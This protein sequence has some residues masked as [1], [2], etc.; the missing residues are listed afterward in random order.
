MKK[1]TF[2]LALSIVLMQCKTEKKESEKV[3]PKVKTT[4]TSKSGIVI[5]NDFESFEKEVLNVAKTQPT[6]INFWATWCAPCMEEMPILLEMQRSEEY[7][8]MNFV[9]V[10]MDFE[11]D[12]E[13]KVKTYIT[14]EKIIANTVVLD[15]PKPNSWIN[16]VSEKW[17]GALPFTMI[18]NNGKT[19]SHDGKLHSLQE[20]EALVKKVEY[21]Q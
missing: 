15:A 5:Y 4:V 19:A 3:T 16:K 12:I 9:F 11:K 17:S 2:L 13:T 7:S 6:L 8:G 21:K 18:T 10:N 14:K 1:I 20:A